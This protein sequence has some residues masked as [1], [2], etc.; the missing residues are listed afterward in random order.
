[1]KKPVSIILTL[2][3]LLSAVIIPASASGSSRSFQK[4]Q[5]NAHIFHM[6][7][8]D[9]FTCLFFDDLPDVPYISAEDYLS[10]V[11]TVK[12]DTVDHHDGTY[13]VS[14]EDGEMLVDT[15]KDTVHF[16]DFEQFC[17]YDSQD[18][19]EE[20]SADYIDWTTETEYI[21]EHQGVDLDLSKYDLDLVG[22]DGMVYFP[23]YTISDIFS[24]VYLSAIYRG[25]EIYFVRSQDDEPYYDDSE[26]YNNLAREDSMIEFTYNELCFSID[27]FYGAPPKAEIAKDIKKKGFDTAIKEYDATTARARN[28]LLSND[29]VDFCKGL[30]ILD[31]YFGDGGHT[32][33]SGGMISAMNN[34]DTLFSQELK[35]ALNNPENEDMAAI[36]KPIVNISQE[37]S[38]KQELSSAKEAALESMTSVKSW[39]DAKFYENGDTGYFI[40][41]EFKDAVI[42]PFQWSLDYADE[43]DMKNF[44]IDVT[45]NGGGAQAVVFYMLSMISGD[46][47]LYQ[48]NTFTDNRYKDAPRVDKNLDG[49]FD[50]NDDSVTYDLN[51]AIL[52]SQF[53]FSSANMLPCIAQDHGIAIIGETSGGGTCALAMR[54]LPDGSFYYMSSDMMMTYPDGDD[55]DGGAAPDTELDTSDNYQRFFDFDKIEDGITTFYSSNHNN[56][57]DA[58]KED[59]TVS[60]TEE[61]TEKSNATE[62]ITPGGQHGSSALSGRS[63]SSDMVLLYILFSVMAMILV[64]IILLIVFLARGKKKPQKSTAISASPAANPFQNPTA[65]P[66]A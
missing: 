17:Y 14:R 38:A 13:T 43:H 63:R 37:Q 61:S 4:R 23:L 28:L 22:D 54:Y 15:N 16:D 21:G 7:K 56:Q 32:M 51:F 40:F 2:M 66:A 53:S 10:R 20:E 45:A 29:R 19:N 62:A 35:Q 26:L 50:A 33:L 5:V 12:F 65:S 41:D 64:V 36:A 58:P 9:T 6:S 59:E 8:T 27:H 44:V 46:S 47:A 34:S 52:T 49:A 3:L 11:Y 57:T 60:P 55:I 48:L 30:M 24:D 31:N 1:M 39:D 25:G 18:A 42:K